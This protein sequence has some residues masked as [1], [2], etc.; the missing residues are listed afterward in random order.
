MDPIA[1]LAASGLH[2]R[3]VSLDLLA[4]NLANGATAGYK[5]DRESYGRFV[6]E[7]AT[8]VMDGDEGVATLPQI[9]RQ[10]TDFS[11]G[12][13]QPTGNPF[14][15]A[16]S[17]KGFFAVD[18]P[19]GALYTRNGNFRL[20]STGILTTSQGYA[21]RTAG[22]GT[23]QTR[24]GGT[25]EVSQDG[26]VS[27]DGQALGRLEIVDFPKSESLRKTSGSYFQAADNI[28]PKPATEVQ[29]QQ[30]AIE[31]SNVPVA[32][33]A[34]RIVGIMR[35]FEMLQKAV[36]MAAEMGKESTEQVA[37]V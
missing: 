18:G 26:V 2:A 15:M 34:V 11:Q 35:Q 16:L 6:S 29:V 31:A 32:E 13:L 7:D 23:I 36:M 30:K 9:D 4:N 21:V 20:S 10:W 33:S 28:K 22:G 14:D 8:G 19:K 37:K 3:Q 1:V 5:A 24:N 17:G 25:I 27:Q 12:E